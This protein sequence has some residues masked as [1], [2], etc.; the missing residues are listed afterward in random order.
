MAV[1]R[2]V[3]SLISNATVPA[4]AN[5]VPAAINV[6]HIPILSQAV[7][8]RGAAGTGTA[9]TALHDAVKFAL[10]VAAGVAWQR[11]RKSERYRDMKDDLSVLLDR[12]MA[13]L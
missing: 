10:P 9:A 1:H 3:A 6:V 11:F 13:A 5:A 12:A 4:A 8:S 2:G 7:L